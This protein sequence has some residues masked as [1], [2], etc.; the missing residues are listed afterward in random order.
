MNINVNL[1]RTIKALL[2]SKKHFSPGF[3]P[4]IGYYTAGGQAICKA[5][6]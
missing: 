3:I 5:V 2:G 4:L 1:N 6:G